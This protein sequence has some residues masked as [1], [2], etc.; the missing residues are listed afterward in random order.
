MILDQAL[1]VMRDLV[2]KYN[3]QEVLKIHSR[4][5]RT[6]IQFRIL[7]WNH[8]L[9]FIPGSLSI[10]ALTDSSGMA[11]MRDRQPRLS[12]SEIS[13]KFHVP[14]KAFLHRIWG[15]GHYRLSV[16]LDYSLTHPENLKVLMEWCLQKY[17]KKRGEAKHLHEK[18]CINLMEEI[19]GVPA[20]RNVTP[21]W[22]SV[23]SGKRERLDGYWKPLRLAVEYRGL[24]HYELVP[25]FHGKN[26]ARFQDGLERDEA[27]RRACKEAGID[28]IEI[29]YWVDPTDEGVLQYINEKCGHITDRIRSL[30]SPD[31]AVNN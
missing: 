19:L 27:K 4:N 28:L 8:N 12:R 3:G 16:G 18:L 23:C 15:Q 10:P 6:Y 21:S 25:Y 30:A 9:D 13:T 11:G 7:G 14:E 31:L 5:N 26:E 17:G 22:L 20:A 2:R 24:Q 1:C 29:P